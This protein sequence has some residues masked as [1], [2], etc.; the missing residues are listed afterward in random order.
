[1]V[2]LWRKNGSLGTV[3][4]QSTNAPKTLPAKNTMQKLESIIFLIFLTSPLISALSEAL[5]LDFER[6]FGAIAND[7]APETCAFNTNLLSE[8]LNDSQNTT[9]ILARSNRTIH[10]HNG[11]F[12]AHLRNIRLIVDGILRFERKPNFHRHPHTRSCLHLVNSTN[13]TLTS[14]YLDHRRGVLDGQG[15][16]YWGVSGHSH[17]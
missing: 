1:M 10:F 5:V 2:P 4:P 13:V 14:T 17:K 3:S 16:Q 15:S 6:D 11:V 8:V 7:N 12:G 9:L